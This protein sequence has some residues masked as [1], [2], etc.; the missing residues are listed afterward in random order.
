MEVNLTKCRIRLDFF[1]SKSLLEQKKYLNHAKS[2]RD[3]KLIIQL[4]AHN[5]IYPAY[6]KAQQICVFHIPYIPSHS[7]SLD[8]EEKK[9]VSHCHVPIS[10]KAE[11]FQQTRQW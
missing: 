1:S 11:A 7:E 3:I 10:Q 6:T 9:G 2:Q 5:P 8:G 4:H